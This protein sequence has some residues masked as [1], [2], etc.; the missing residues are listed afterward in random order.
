MALEDR[1]ER[2]A[3]SNSAV[4]TQFLEC[5][6]MVCAVGD[7]RDCERSFG[8]YQAEIAQGEEE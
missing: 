3:F 7:P 2:Q 6:E 1:D 8:L 4:E 5:I